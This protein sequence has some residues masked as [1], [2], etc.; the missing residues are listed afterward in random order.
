VVKSALIGVGGRM[1]NGVLQEFILHRHRT[2]VKTTASATQ[3]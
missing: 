3:P 2:N 1:A